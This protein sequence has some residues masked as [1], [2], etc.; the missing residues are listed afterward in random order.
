MMIIVFVF[1]S[2]FRLSA[3]S[4]QAETSKPAKDAVID[5]GFSDKDNGWA[6]IWSK[7]GTNL[8]LTKNAGETWKRKQGPPGTVYKAYFVDSELGWSI[9]GNADG[10]HLF[11]TKDG[12]DK[13][14]ANSTLALPLPSKDNVILDLHFFDDQ[15]GWIL[16]QRAT[17]E[18]TL[19]LK[20]TDGG[21][22]IQPENG[23]SESHFVSIFSAPKGSPILLV[24]LENHIAKEDGSFQWQL[25]KAGSY[26]IGANWFRG[27]M[28]SS[29]LGV[30]VGEGPGGII[31]KTE[32]GGQNW[33][34]SLIVKS[35]D[36]FLDVSFVD[37]NFGCAVGTSEFLYC[38]TDSGQHWN[39]RLKLP[40]PSESDQA[41]LFTRLF[42]LDLNHAYLI[43]DGGYIYKSID[44]GKSW[45]DAS[46]SFI[47]SPAVNSV[48]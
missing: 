16:V 13:W 9:C 35:T 37:A 45:V 27:A 1:A 15:R 38:T 11:S 44:G 21:K 29:T 23:L 6:I 34:P 18:G 33:L 47:E 22:T 39:S 5:M 41:K 43:R 36:A 48:H 20:T 10:W 30:I 46:S 3:H 26:G 28:L 25:G 17:G 7:H 42:F 12:G 8:F 40:L 32:D 4:E 19:V 2:L 14:V 24:G 31:L